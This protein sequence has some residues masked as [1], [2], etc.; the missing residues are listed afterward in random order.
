[1]IERLI[2]ETTEFDF[3]EALETKKPKSWLKSISAFANGGG[4]KLIF[5]VDNNKN[6]VG[7]DNVQQDSEVISKLIQERITPLPIFDL[8]TDLVDSKNILI[9]SVSSGRS[10]P[11]YYKADGIMKAYIRAGNDSVGAP[12]LFL[13]ELILKGINL[14]FDI[15]V[16]NNRKEDYS[17]TLFE[18]TYRE[19]TGICFES[20]DFVSFR[21]SDNRGF[22]TNAGS[23][24]SD[25]YIVFNSRLFCTRWN[26][27]EKGSI[28]DDALDNKEYEGNLFYLMQSGYDFVRNNSKIRFTKKKRIPN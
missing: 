24:M 12:P 9:L 4:G 19:R 22:L 6:I 20:S 15:L 11:Y 23:M 7:L 2:A 21:L 27:L 14:S 18:A 8:K 10:T 25:Q 26:G 3:K 16:T 28:F 1:M 5:G 13:N 17:F